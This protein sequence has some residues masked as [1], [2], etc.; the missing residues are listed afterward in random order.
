MTDRK[1]ADIN[2]GA[3]R[4]PR[5]ISNSRELYDK[6]MAVL[7]S[8]QADGHSLLEIYTQKQRVYTNAASERD[9]AFSRAKEREGSAY[10]D[11]VEENGSRYRAIVNAAYQDWV[12]NGGKNEVEYWLGLFDNHG[13]GGEELGS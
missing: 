2:S 4:I 11:W 5:S 12:V 9:R 13:D 1:D 7:S 10:D 6:A 8:K 3:S